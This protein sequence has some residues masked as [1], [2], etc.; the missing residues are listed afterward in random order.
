MKHYAI[1]GGIGSGKST[2]LKR[3]KELGIPTFSADD[4]AKYAMENNPEVKQKIIALF[5]DKSY[6]NGALNRELLAEQVFHNKSKLEALNAVVHPAAR[7]AYEQWRDAQDAPYTMYEVSILFELHAQ[8]RFDGVLLVVTAEEERIK[9]VQIRD[10]VTEDNVRARIKNQWP[11]EQKLPLADFVIEN[12][13]LSNTEVQVKA[14]HQQ[15]LEES[16]Q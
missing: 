7:V 2:V 6:T 15:L 10:K 16:K 11:D 12:T 8:D 1:T 4:S 14:L 5:G 13:D 9:R 3:F